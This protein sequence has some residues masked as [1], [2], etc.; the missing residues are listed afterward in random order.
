VAAGKA[1]AAMTSA[2]RAPMSGWSR[3]WRMVDTSV[4]SRS[5]RRIVSP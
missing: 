3:R 2:D 5:G 4:G 1:A